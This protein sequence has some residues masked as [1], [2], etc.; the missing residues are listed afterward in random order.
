[1]P[2]RATL[3]LPQTTCI[4]GDHPIAPRIATLA[5]VVN[6]PHRG[7][8]GGLRVVFV[9]AMLVPGAHLLWQLHSLDIDRP[10]LCL[11]LFKSNRDTGALITAAL[12]LG[13]MVYGTITPPG[14][15][16]MATPA[17][18]LAW[19]RSWGWVIGLFVAIEMITE[20]VA[21]ISLALAA[22]SAAGTN[23]PGAVAAPSG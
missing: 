9:I 17:G 19:I 12:V 16:A 15:E 22:K 11:R 3:G 4:G 20:G 7:V 18:Q 1:M 10:L 21:L 14:A 5:E 13:A 8:V 23:A 2:R 6:Q